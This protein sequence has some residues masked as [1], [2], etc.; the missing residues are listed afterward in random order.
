MTL[1]ILIC[2]LNKG[3][4]R[5]QDVLLPPREGLHYVVSYQYTD[6]RNLDLVPE[7]L[8]S[9]PDVSLYIYK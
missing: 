6:E 2:S 4:V 8:R 3:I 5:I 1:D 9:R 7:V